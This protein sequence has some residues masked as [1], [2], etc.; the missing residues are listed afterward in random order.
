MRV[1][2][3]ISGE[4]GCPEPTYEINNLFANHGASWYVCIG[5]QEVLMPTKTIRIDLEAYNRL[6]R[7]QHANESFS[8]TIKRVVPKSISTEKLI[9]LFRKV[10]PQLSEGFFRGVES[11]IAAR[12]SDHALKR[13]R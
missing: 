7:V 10:G 1:D 12:N 11:A 9:S 5:I 8:E 4:C 13:P 2:P 3:R 6:K